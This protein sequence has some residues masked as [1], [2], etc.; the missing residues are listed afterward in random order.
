LLAALRTDFFLAAA[1]DVLFFLADFWA[2]RFLLLELLATVGFFAFDLGLALCAV[3]FGGSAPMPSFPL[4]LV[5]TISRNISPARL[6]APPR[7]LPIVFATSVNGLPPDFGFC[8][9]AIYLSRFA[10]M[11]SKCDATAKRI[12]PL[13]L[14][15]RNGFAASGIHFGLR[16]SSHS[17]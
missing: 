10:K 5:G 4:I 1:L 6:A 8:S 15:L 14:N 17:I 13:V 7:V 3:L 9:S 11:R 12:L 16:L 2:G